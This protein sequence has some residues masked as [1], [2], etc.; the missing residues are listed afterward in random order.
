MARRIR[1]SAMPFAAACAEAACAGIQ[2]RRATGAASTS[3]YNN[4]GE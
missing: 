3:V 1:V 4:V 2:P